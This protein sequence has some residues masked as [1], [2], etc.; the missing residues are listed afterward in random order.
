MLQLKKKA[1]A[2]AKMRVLMHK[3]VQNFI[4]TQNVRLQTWAIN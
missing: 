3:N 4:E 1:D 2:Q